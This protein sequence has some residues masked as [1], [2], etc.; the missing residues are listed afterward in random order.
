ML[1]SSLYQIVMIFF[2]AHRIQYVIVHL[3]ERD[4]APSD[5][6]QIRMYQA[7]DRES[8]THEL[9]HIMSTWLHFEQNQ[10]T[11]IRSPF[12]RG[13]RRLRQLVLQ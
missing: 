13:L 8:G 1:D 5:V 4:E 11:K 6:E 3:S 12:S 9:K 10:T 7:M 2:S